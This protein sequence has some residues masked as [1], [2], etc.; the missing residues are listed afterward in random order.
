[1]NIQLGKAVVT[2]SAPVVA[3]EYTTIT[4]KYTVEHPIDDT[5]F[6]KIVFRYAGDFGTPQ[7]ENPCDANFCSVSTTG[8]CR[9]ETRW[10]PKGHTRPWGKGMYLKVMGGFLDKNDEITVIFGDT[11]NGSPGWQ[12]QTFV[13]E[14]FEFKTF[15]DPF[16]T[17]DF[18]ELEASPVIQVSHGE[19][20]KAVCIA[21][22]QIKVGK[23]FEYFLKL[24][25]KWGNPVE[26][27][28]I[29]QHEGFQCSGIETIFVKDPQSGLCAV[30]NPIKVSKESGL[31][32]FWADFHGQTEETIG[33]NSIRDY[34]SFAKDFALLDISAHQGNDFQVTDSFWK[35]VNDVSDEFNCDDAFVTFPGFEWSGNTPFGG[36]RNVYYKSSG[37]DIFR[38]SAELLPNKQTT[39]KLAQTANELFNDLK[40]KYSFV[41]AHVGGRYADM[42][43]HDPETEVAVEIHS[44][45]GT[46]EWLLE[47]AFK[48]CYRVGICANSDGH[49]C[50]PGAS[51]PGASKFGSYGGLTCVLSEKLD[52]EHIFDAMKKRHF[53]A[54]TGNRPLIDLK[55][56][57]G[58]E[59]G[60][61]G[62]I[63]KAA[64]KVFLKASIVGTAPIEKITL[65]NGIEILKELRPY[66]ESE[67]GNRIKI[68]WSGAEVRGRDR[69]CRWDGGLKMEGNIIKDYESVN[70]WNP[71]RKIEKLS[72]E[73]LR[74]QSITT[75]G[76]AGVIIEL[77]S[78]DTGEIEISTM[79]G[80]LKCALS[81]I[82]I[83][84]KFNKLGGL[85][86]KIAVYRL[87]KKEK[88][89]CCFEL[90][91]SVAS[92]KKGNNPVYMKVEQ[93]D[94]H[95]AWTSP[96]Y[97]VK[98]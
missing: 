68:V 52:R 89:H 3:G 36:D 19:A 20:V 8:D 48:L 35:T 51:Y 33:T 97:I 95:M 94:G 13:E 6:I 41:F 84:E 43:M 58:N 21:P 92:L 7:F 82:S 54:T 87:P 65:R 40:G 22:S 73:E 10:N 71:D 25:D 29:M 80:N 79:S 16:A 15:V 83:K 9:I 42:N 63:I 78:H 17:Y 11:S 32:Y 75:G 39:F 55:C 12:V 26:F 2:S 81:D 44:A 56:I 98:N 77:E 61:M 46:F 66:K 60:V 86:K 24:E 70:F 18:K 14:T 96:V 50:R 72:S 30:S 31:S 28:A 5:G 69:L 47:E 34:Y 76:L 27:P 57:S 38:S 88:A 49:K 4:Y 64:N 62:D 93:E 90:E 23:A 1:M 45:W 85:E 37:E 67:L 59:G 74:W 91:E 53:Y